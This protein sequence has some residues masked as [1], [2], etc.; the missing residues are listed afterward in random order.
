MTKCKGLRELKG[1]LIVFGVVGLVRGSQSKG[2][3]CVCEVTEGAIGR[4]WFQQGEGFLDDGWCDED[5]RL[6][7]SWLAGVGVGAGT[8]VDTWG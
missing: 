4:T 6:I 1:E 7:A 8:A 2:L 3:N 5:G